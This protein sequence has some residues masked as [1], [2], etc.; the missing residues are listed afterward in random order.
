MILIYLF[1]VFFILFI[2]KIVPFKKK[3][4]SIIFIVVFN[5]IVYL[6]LPYPLYA[7]DQASAISSL[8]DKFAK[9]VSKRFCNSLGFG[10]SKE[11]ALKFSLTENTIELSKKK[12]FRSM[13][14]DALENKISSEISNKCGTTFIVNER[15][16]YNELKVL[17]SNFDLL[18]LI[19]SY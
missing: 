4:L 17:I 15:E 10:I 2:I 14:I 6:S 11:S 7:K 12:L 18:N 9:S 8:E 5:N 16:G 1:C 13:N 19:N 3:L